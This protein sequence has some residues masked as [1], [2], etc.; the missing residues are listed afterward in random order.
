MKSLTVTLSAAVIL[1]FVFFIQVKAD[2]VVGTP[3]NLGPP[4]S[5]AGADAGAIVS[6]DGLTLYFFDDN[7]DIKTSHRTTTEEPWGPPVLLPPPIN[8]PAHETSPSLSWD[9]LSL[10]FSDGVFHSIGPRAGSEGGGDLWVTD[11]PSDDSPWRDPQ[12]LG[13]VVNSTYF[14]GGPSISRD[15]LSLFFGSDRPGGSGSFDV[16]VTTRPNL[17]AEWGAPVNLGSQINGPA[18][19]VLPSIS[20]D[21][22]VLFFESD[23]VGRFDL[24]YATRNSVSEEFGPAS[25]FVIDPL[26]HL[27]QADIMPFITQDSSTLMF[28]SIGRPGGLGSW[29]LWQV[30]IKP[31]VDFDGSETV[32]L[33]DL[34]RLIESWGQ[35]DPAVDIGPTAF[36]DGVVDAA[37]LEVLMSY[38]GQE[39]DDPTLKAFWKLDETDGDIAY[40]SGTEND[41]IVMGDAVWQP[42]GGRVGGALRLDGVDDYVNTLFALNPADTVFSVFAWV[43]GGAPGQVILS[44]IDGMNWLM[45]DAKGYLKTRLKINRREKDLTSAVAINNDTWHR[46][47]F[48]WDGT[49]RILYVDDHE[50]ARDTQGGLQKSHGDLFIGAGS[51][52]DR[53]TFWSGMIDDV[54]IYDRVVTP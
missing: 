10:Y 25:L 52:L 7:W 49:N 12:N 4:V 40:D 37:D 33:G 14:E 48:T 43:K 21:G 19:D 41:A 8:S 26:G 18:I 6:V 20:A 53:S 35:E 11:R 47:G 15:G 28:T 30:S 31:V 17:N 22:L 39:V 32:D 36:G 5:T 46:V 9:G 50:V 23:R 13:P 3:E 42:E 16:W 1:T 44:Q 34:L 24:W 27:S 2:F 38:W 54:R 45:L 51:N 29:D